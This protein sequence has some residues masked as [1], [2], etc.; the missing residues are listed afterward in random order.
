MPVGF[1]LNICQFLSWFLHSSFFLSLLL[2][3]CVYFSFLFLSSLL[4]L[5]FK[6]S[7]I[8]LS[9]MLNKYNL[10]IWGKS[11]QI[12]LWGSLSPGWQEKPILARVEKAMKVELSSSFF[13]V[14]LQTRKLTQISKGPRTIG[15]Q[16]DNRNFVSQ[17]ERLSEGNQF[18]SFLTNLGPSHHCSWEAG[19]W[20]LTSSGSLSHSLMGSYHLS[21]CRRTGMHHTLWGV[22][23]NHLPVWRKYLCFL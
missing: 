3:I 21:R 17:A 5:Y 11:N 15:P 23:P 22:C 13:R 8:A 18:C 10:F 19:G 14:L 16:V 12:C 4:W 20:S 2:L 1:H 9:Q 7:L 6:V